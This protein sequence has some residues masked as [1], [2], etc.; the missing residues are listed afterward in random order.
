M[1]EDSFSDKFLKNYLLI[2][3]ERAKL[4]FMPTLLENEKL[5]MHKSGKCIKV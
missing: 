1:F 4:S 5:I 2:I 3:L